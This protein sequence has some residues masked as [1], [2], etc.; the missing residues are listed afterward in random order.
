MNVFEKYSIE[1]INKRTRISPISLRYI[2]NKEF[3]K[4]PRVKFI[5]FI[6]IIENEFKVDLSDLIKEYEEAT[7]HIK[8]DNIEIKL[9]NPKKNGNFLIILFAIILIIIGGYYLYKTTK[10]NPNIL[11]EQNYSI[12]Q[13]IENNLTK[14]QAIL[15]KTKEVEKIKE[16]KKIEKNIE[17]NIIEN[18]ITNITENNSTKENNITIQNKT[19]FNSIQIIPKEKVWFKAINLDTNKTVE[20]LTSSP[21]ELNGSN[22]Y[23]KLG[24]GFVTIKYKDKTITPNTKKIVRVLLKNGKYEFLKKPNRYEK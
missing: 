23:I 11:V 6:R 24:H 13:K 17:K 15:K 19:N 14:N 18:N 3:S 20:Y 4:I 22:W 12:T 9:E 2:K 1:E 5:G 7:K 21:K 16:I 10:Q 8:K